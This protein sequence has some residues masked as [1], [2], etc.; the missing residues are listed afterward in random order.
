MAIPSVLSPEE[1]A[2]LAVIGSGP[3]LG[4]SIP[5]EHLIA[6]VRLRYVYAVHGCFEATV[7]GKSRIARGV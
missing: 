4:A 1:F 7:A 2:S 3:T 5:I 6:L